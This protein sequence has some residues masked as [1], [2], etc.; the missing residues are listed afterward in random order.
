MSTENEF[1]FEKARRL[2]I[3]RR[4]ER[5][6]ISFYLDVQKIMRGGRL[7]KEGVGSGFCNSRFY[8]GFKISPL[9]NVY[10]KQTKSLMIS[11]DAGCLSIYLKEPGK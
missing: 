5:T 4:H 3:G 7:L 1:A 2:Q 11:R 8:H 9:W 6:F 10:Q